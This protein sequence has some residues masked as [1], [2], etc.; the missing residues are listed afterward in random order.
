MHQNARHREGEALLLSFAVPVVVM[1]IVFIVRGIFPFGENCF[2]RTDLYHQYAPFFS[3]FQ[4]KLKSG[5]SLLYSWD[6]GLGVNFSAI[7]AYY[8][9]SPV[10]WFLIL[11]PKGALIEVMT[12]LIVVKTGLCG[13]TMTWYLRHREQGKEE[14]IYAALFGIFYALSGY[15]CAYSWNIM[16][17]DCIFLFPLVC[18]GVERLA[19]GK[20]RFLYVF[21]LALS[22]ASNYY[23]S[24]MTCI[25]LVLYFISLMVVKKRSVPEILQASGEFAVG[26]LIAGA[27]AALV[28]LPAVFA[29][30]STA[31]GNFNFPKTWTLYFPIF[32]MLARHMAGVSTEI[33]LD[34]WPNI[35][36][37]TAVYQLMV[38]YVLN[39]KIPFREK[40]VYGTLLF[41]FLAGFSVDVLNYMW[42]GFHYPN[43]LPCRQSFIYIL[44]VLLL[45]ERALSYRDGNTKKDLKISFFTAFVFVLL[46]QKL[47]DQKHFHFAVYFAAMVLVCLYAALI[48]EFR[49][50]N[51]DRRILL[52]LTVA[53]VASEGLGN[54]AATSVPTTSRTEYLRGNDDITALRDSVMPEDGEVDFFR[55]ERIKRKS[56]DD[57]AWL[58][59][60]SVSLFSSTARAP[61]S[62]FMKSLGCESSVNAYSI[63]GSTPLVDSLLDVR[64]AFYSSECMNPALKEA[65]RSGD[66]WLYENPS[67]FPL[68][69]LIS[70]GLTD[71][72][73]RTLENPADVQND[74]CSLNG[75]PPVLVEMD[76]RTDGKNFTFTADRDGEYYVFVTN[77]KV[78]K[79]KADLPGGTKTFDN[80]KRRFFLE[81]DRLYEGETAALRIDGESTGS[82]DAKAYRFDY[83]A[84]EALKRE[85]IYGNF[86]LTEFGSDHFAGIA[87]ADEQGLVLMTSVPYDA[88]WSVKIDGSEAET[89]ELFEALL[90][91]RV[92]KGTHTLEFSFKPEGRTMGF[93]IS[94]VAWAAILL[95]FFYERR[96]WK[97]RKA[98]E[99]AAEVPAEEDT[100]KGP[101]EGLEEDLEENLEE[102]RAEYPEEDPEKVPEQNWSGEPRESSDPV[103]PGNRETEETVSGTFEA[104]HIW[105]ASG[106]EGE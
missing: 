26:S 91:V 89:E 84:L 38:L 73:V 16:W 81:L 97:L 3:E 64:Y 35:F 23:I 44:L 71:N 7:Y 36:C 49:N 87:E 99:A 88:G 80:L 46:C 10:N 12:A 59:F 78:D 85:I 66:I 39:R 13:V 100:E 27:A 9:A 102:D 21:T 86:E 24:I 45:S 2:L 19:D 43:S 22:I 63:T 20:E 42:H 11:V 5:E 50:G 53:L 29:L 25:F 37:G 40:A 54:M 28:V 83:K 68:G 62:A 61:L 41:L 69:F 33:G 47:V 74:L 6:V 90:G 55:F 18:L 101:E 56:K 93:L 98:R 52:S 32:D 95:L 58:N 77:A 30:R 1:L 4:H 72:W 67:V 96:L 76:G 60:P 51:M 48:L 70:G 92:P 57:G 104:D 15:L 105:Q 65:G 31:S 94:A 8:L 82:L 79:V 103:D 75:V 17:L 106:R 34:H 14:G